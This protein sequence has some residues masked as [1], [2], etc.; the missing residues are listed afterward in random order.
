[1]E[2]VRTSRQAPHYRARSRRPYLSTP[3]RPRFGVIGNRFD[4]RGRERNPTPVVWRAL[5]AS[6]QCLLSPPCRCPSHPEGVA[7]RKVPRRS[8]RSVRSA[9]RPRLE[10][11]RLAWHIR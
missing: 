2:A 11:R 7:P 8:D 9:F 10:C 5:P 6:A 1:M 3:D 4:R